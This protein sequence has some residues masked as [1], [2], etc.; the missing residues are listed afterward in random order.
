[1]ATMTQAQFNAQQQQQALQAFMA[2]EQQ[3]ALRK[4]DLD[5]MRSLEQIAACPVTGGSGTTAAYTVGS[6]IYFDLPVMPSGFAKGLLIKYN[7]TSVL[8]ATGT[9]A[10]YALNKAAQF[11]I[12]SEIA[13]QYNGGQIRTHPYF[14]KVQDQIK[15]FLRGAQNGVLAGQNDSYVS[16]LIN[17]ATPITVNAA[18]VWQGQMY[19]PLNALSEDDVKGI[20]PVSGA[21]THAQLK[22]TTP[23]N[24]MGNDPL[25]NPI[26]TT[27]GTGA[28]VTATGTIS[29]DMIYLTGS[30]L[31]SPQLLAPPPSVYGPTLQYFWEPSLSPLLTNAI[32]RQTVT[33]K[34][35]HHLMCSIV[36]DG[37]QSTDFAKWSNVTQFEL[38]GDATGSQ[39]LK[40]WNVSNNVPVSDYFD[41]EIR[42]RIGQDLDEGV[43]L[44]VASPVR[45]T[46]NASNRMGNMAANM[47]PGGF[48][49]LTH[50]YNVVTPGSP[51]GYSPRVETFL[52]SE[53]AKGLGLQQVL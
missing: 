53:N 24:F 46:V 51:T 13:L 29:V 39:K 15:G 11:A 23:A 48:P 41:R 32:S 35:R 10:T 17:G 19:L 44:W 31:E 34:M 49:T 38:T 25:I 36:I 1:M 3:N 5:F 26:A 52:V 47:Y 43:I 40:S 21:G 7:F 22:L 30:D 37:A 4:Q 6:T 42:R 50:G 18:N 27:G 14:L 33:N 2:R 12:F 45:G 16:N 8:P 20:L 9:S 28:A